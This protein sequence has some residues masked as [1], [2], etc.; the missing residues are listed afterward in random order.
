M[1]VL[2][3]YA[4]KLLFGFL[5]LILGQG[6][7]IFGEDKLATLLDCKSVMR[8]QRRVS[9]AHHNQWKKRFSVI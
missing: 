3:I 9:A 5:W 7:A 8:Q 1:H 2:C 4:W 6:L